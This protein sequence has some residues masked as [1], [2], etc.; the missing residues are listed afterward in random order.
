MQLILRYAARKAYPFAK[1]I[2]PILR[3]DHHSGFRSRTLHALMSLGRGAA[4]EIS[5]IAPGWSSMRLV[6]GL[7][8]AVSGKYDEAMP[9]FGAAVRGGAHVDVI[10]HYL[11]VIEMELGY[12]AIAERLFTEALKLQPHW[13]NTLISLGQV[14]LALDCEQRALPALLKAIALD[15]KFGMAHQ[16]LAARYDRRSYRPTKLDKSGSPE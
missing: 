4:R 13:A 10:Y 3:G 2:I 1:L 15:P 7:F 11:G 8:D 5:Q 9:H 12:Y 16:N 6:N 14:R